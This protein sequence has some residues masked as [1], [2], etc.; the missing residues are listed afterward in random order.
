MKDLESYGVLKEDEW[1]YLPWIPD[2]R[3]PFKIWLKPEAIE[4]FFIIQ[5]YPY[6]LSLL[7]K[8]EDGFQVDTFHKIG[9]EGNSKDWE[10]LTKGLIQEYELDNSGEDLF[11]FDS[12]KDIFCV[13]SQYIDDLMRL[14]K[15]IRATCNDEALMLKYINF[16]ETQQV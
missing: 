6:A 15:M 4:P 16:D 3:P 14:A 5:H 2:P 10:T 13:F 1:E 7:L 11:H 12:D 8:I 9:L